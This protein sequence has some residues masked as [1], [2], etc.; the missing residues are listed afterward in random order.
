MK[1]LLFMVLAI[2]VFAGCSKEENEV[3]SEGDKITRSIKQIDTPLMEVLQ[4]IP[5]WTELRTFTYTEPD[6][7]GEEITL[8]DYVKNPIPADYGSPGWYAQGTIG[9]PDNQLVFYIF[10][11]LIIHR[12]HYYDFDITKIED[13]TFTFTRNN[14]E[15]YLKVLAYNKD[16]IWV[17]TNCYDKDKNYQK[18]YGRADSYP[19]VRTLFVNEK[20]W[21]SLHT[22]MSEDEI[23]NDMKENPDNYPN[24][25]K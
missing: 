4:S 25:N 18:E 19:Y 12:G 20:I 8:C 5:Y 9:F 23:K 15:Y 14:E 2:A 16:Y 24:W 1:K 11:T 21:Y 13:N 17:E 22:F 6:G 10:S 7:K 3:L